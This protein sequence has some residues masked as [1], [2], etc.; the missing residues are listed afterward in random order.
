MKIC[1]FA[2]PKMQ[3]IMSEGLFYYLIYGMLVLA[4]VV[5]VSL[6]FVTAGY[7]QF[8]TKQWG[9]SVNN[10][11]GWVLME[12]PV[13]IVMLAIW[14]L[15]PLRWHL[16]QLALFCLFEL[17]YFQR[18]LVFPFL[19]KGQSRMPVAIMLMGIVFNLINGLIQGGGLYWFPNPDFEQ[20]VSYLLRP[21]AIAGILLF[22]IG[23]AINLHSD[24]VVRHLRKPG[25]TKHYLPSKGMYRYVTSANY[26]GEIIEW[27][28]F[29]IAAATLAA[30]VFPIWTAA[31]LV[32]R[33]HAIYNRY[34][35][36]FGEEALGKRKRIV[37]F[38]Y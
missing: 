4:I 5:F 18:S 34:K 36:E 10:K 23:M 13:F 38:V 6:Y 32:P 9:L 21:N 20:G 11:L 16:P 22:F 27:T 25:D 28:G 33:A 30:W 37:P 14:S 3:G 15:S 26:L 19:L 8:R 29:A 35:E 24:H 12:V 17:H 31:N 2:L 7:G 1:N